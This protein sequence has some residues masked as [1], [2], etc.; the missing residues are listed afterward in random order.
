MPR[1]RPRGSKSNTKPLATHCK[2][3]HEFTPENT[4]IK[5]ICITCQIGFVRRCR[6]KKAGGP[7]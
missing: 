5:R 3:G 7:R 4:R 2:A 6:E 1:G